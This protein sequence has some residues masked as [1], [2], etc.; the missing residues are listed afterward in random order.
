MNDHKKHAKLSASGSHRWL[1][2][3]GSVL[4]EADFPEDVVSEFAEYGTAGHE[5]A[6]LCLE[7]SRPATLFEGQ[8]LNKSKNFPE[9]FLV[10]GEMAD[11]VQTYLD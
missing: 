4:L 6:Q 2:C 3:P 8:Y 1:V 9:G 11:A 7:K 10:D 5:L